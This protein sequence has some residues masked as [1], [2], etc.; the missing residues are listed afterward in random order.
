MT[1]TGRMDPCKGGMRERKNLANS[2]LN[3][4]LSTRLRFRLFYLVWGSH[5]SVKSCS[6][7]FLQVDYHFRGGEKLG[8]IVSAALENTIIQTINSTQVGGTSGQLYFFSHIF[9]CWSKSGSPAETGNSWL[10][11]GQP[12]P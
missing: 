9:N 6:C 10:Q 5:Q 1:M 2:L 8:I 4:G 12:P 3:L 11:F 7:K